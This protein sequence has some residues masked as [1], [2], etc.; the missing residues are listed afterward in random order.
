MFMILLHHLVVHNVVD[1]KAM[2]PGFFRFLLQFVL[3]S[4]GKVGVVIFFA[5]SA[6]FLADAA[7]GIKVSLRRV[8][9]LEKEVLF[10]CTILG[11]VCYLTMDSMGVGSLVR[12]FFP[13][14]S[15]AWWYATAYA[16]F[17][18]VFPF[19]VDG[20]RAI[21]R[22]RHL[23]LCSVLF[24]FVGIIGMSPISPIITG[25]MGMIYLFILITA[26]KWYVAP[27]HPFN[28][29]KLIVT[30]LI[31]LL[32]YVLASLLVK[33]LLD[34]SVGAY[35]TSE[36]KTPILLIGFG[37]FLLFE[38]V[39][40]YSSIV[41]TVA[42]CSFAV[43]LITEFHP[44]ASCI[45]RGP[46]S[47]DAMGGSPF[48]FVGALALCVAMYAACSLADLVRQRAFSKWIDSF[49]ESLYERLWNALMSRG[50]AL[51]H[52]YEFLRE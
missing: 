4:G 17:L 30:G 29:V 13:L 8:W 39:Q 31:L 38:R 41:N 43:Y 47:L 12:S 27:F 24:F 9:R 16:E 15:S 11:I 36:T 22:K 10:Y 14:M 2:E 49:W 21:R 50:K 18:I 26:Y 46:F 33:S 45:W 20:L 28:P 44:I 5:I 42:S 51:F 1:Y 52:F 19:L 6:W 35:I 23:V 37:I 3:V 25:A 7:A 32:P 40:F 34:V 48:G